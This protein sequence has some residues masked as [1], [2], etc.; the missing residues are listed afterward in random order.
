VVAE[1]LSGAFM[2]FAP[3]SQGRAD[4]KGASFDT[5]ALVASQHSVPL[6]VTITLHPTWRAVAE[7]S[8]VF[9]QG[10]TRDGKAFRPSDWAERLAGA[11][12]CF[13]PEGSVGGPAAFIGYSPYCVPRI[14]GGVKGVVVNP[15]L[16]ELEP[17]AWDFVMNFARDNDLAVVE[18]PDLDAP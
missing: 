13:R 9:I 14:V 12:S 8:E 2:A 6:P 18:H 10:Q 3:G 16:R 11:M 17:M 4:S 5:G 7:S 1:S 15:K